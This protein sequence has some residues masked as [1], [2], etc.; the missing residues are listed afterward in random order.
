MKTIMLS[1]AELVWQYRNTRWE[2]QDYDNLLNYL[3]TF[4]DKDD[5]SDFTKNNARLY[6]FLSQFTWEQICDWCENY[7]TD[8][9]Q[10]EY[11]NHYY[12]G[13]IWRHSETVS[14]IIKD[15]IREEN[16]SADVV[17]EDYADDYNEEW[18]YPDYEET[19]NEQ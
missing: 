13:Q 17:D 7:N 19:S 12:D 5:Q 2:K 18:I 9:P 11:E 1:R 4:K 6:D 16:Y 14:D 3:K 15:Y 10:F 8:E